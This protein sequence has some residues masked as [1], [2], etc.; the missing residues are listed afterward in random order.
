MKKLYIDPPQ[1]NVMSSSSF[2][3]PSIIGSMDPVQIEQLALRASA[4]GQG[5]SVPL[6]AARIIRSNTDPIRAHT[7]RAPSGSITAPE[8]WPDALPRWK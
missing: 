4:D 7:V 6:L 2:A 5:V 3:L 1:E 8:H